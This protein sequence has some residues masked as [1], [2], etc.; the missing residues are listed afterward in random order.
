MNP[1]TTV[2]LIPLAGL[3]FLGLSGCVTTERPARSLSI[4]AAWQ[5]SA[6]TKALDTGAL[7]RWW[8]RFDDPTLNQ[9]VA[10]T[11]ANNTDLR[12]A[13][14]LVEES[15]AQRGVTRSALLPSLDGSSSAQKSRSHDSGGSDT[16]SSYSASLQPSWE[17]DLSGKL[18]KD[19]QA[20]DSDLA[21]AQENLHALQVS[22]SAE[23]ADAYVSLRVAEAQLD[24]IKRNVASSQ[25]TADV[26]RWE[27]QAGEGTTF[28]TQQ[29]KSTLEQARAS[30]PDA[31]QA[32][33]EAK[34]RITLLAG[35]APGALDSLLARGS[36]IPAPPATIATGIPADTL[37]NRPDVRAAEYAFAAA[38][39][40]TQSAEREQYP[41]LTLSGSLGLEALS[42]GT[43]FSPETTAANAL[44][45]L[46]AP[47]FNGGRIRENINIQ[48]AREK[49]A[50]IT[51]ESTIL[52][53]L[54]E[55]EDALIAIR[56]TNS[57][58]NILKGAVDSARQAE[59]L[60]R[61]NYKAGEIDLLDVLTAQRTLLSLEESQALAQGSLS[62]A[63]IQLYKALGGGWSK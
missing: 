1:F 34:N 43:I 13:V 63:H 54:S 19:L 35:L 9:L 16:S 38:I 40:R 47:I 59:K 8:K 58:L 53:A 57:R 14:S 61:L 50:L 36:D 21:E 10:K 32:I 11:L 25:E 12:T 45:N 56:W 29:A 31:E 55:V 42:T 49:Q 18:A 41:S 52:T 60:A 44:G 3:T 22:L 15:R 48:T 23:M 6:N 27:E 28:S 51:W 37:R 39:A 20:A 30:I 46:T 4:P 5:H 24:I 26:T 17:V 33:R 2:S 62:S 7:T